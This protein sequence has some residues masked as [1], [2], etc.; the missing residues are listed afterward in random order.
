M[1]KQKNI[2]CYIVGIARRYLSKIFRACREGGCCTVALFSLFCL[3]RRR[4]RVVVVGL[5][6]YT[7]YMHSGKTQLHTHNG[8]PHLHPTKPIKSNP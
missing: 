6:R 8:Y 5:E 1:N 3:W 4:R 2:P 7:P